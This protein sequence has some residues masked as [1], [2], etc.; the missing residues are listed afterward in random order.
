MRALDRDIYLERKIAR[1]RQQRRERIEQMVMEVV[2]YALVGTA[3]ILAATIL[4][5]AA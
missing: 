1:K 2:L 4:G 3:A 5:F